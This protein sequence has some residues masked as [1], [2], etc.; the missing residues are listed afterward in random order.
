MAGTECA[1]A[2]Q[3]WNLNEET[4]LAANAILGDRRDKRRLLGMHGLLR[5]R[6]CARPAH[7]S[8]VRLPLRPSLSALL[9]RIPARSAS[10]S[11]PHAAAVAYGFFDPR[12]V[13]LPG[14][15][16]AELAKQHSRT[17]YLLVPVATLN[18][19]CLGSVFAWSMFNQPLMRLLG[20][21]APAAADW[22]LGD[23]TLT[24]SLIMG[25][26]AWGAVFS[27]HLDR[28]VRAAA[29]PPAQRR[30]GDG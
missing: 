14:S 12:R 24:F 4:L 11:S 13:V 25:G 5:A 8:A 27:K 18:H 6:P 21:V 10:G 20:V 29:P 30:A 23:V 9:P 28:M 7:R 3:V 17:R 1:S 26:F 2:A 19:V 15:S 16:G 22:T